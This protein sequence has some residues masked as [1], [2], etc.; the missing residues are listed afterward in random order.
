LMEAA[1]RPVQFRLLDVAE[2]HVEACNNLS[3]LLV[4]AKGSR[5]RRASQAGMGHLALK[6]VREVG[7][8]AEVLF[9]VDVP[10]R[11]TCQMDELLAESIVPCSCTGTG[12]RRTRYAPGSLRYPVAPRLDTARHGPAWPAGPRPSRMTNA[13][14]PAPATASSRAWSGGL[15][16]SVLLAE[17]DLDE[18]RTN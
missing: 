9:G 3:R 8:A 17:N 4:G 13:T 1:G 18:S 5:E 14:L 2:A 16:G 10:R 6:I 12:R 7:S 15:P 11:I